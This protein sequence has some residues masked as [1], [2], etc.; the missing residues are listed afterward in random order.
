MLSRGRALWNCPLL[1][2]MSTSANATPPHASERP[3]QPPP[4]RLRNPDHIANTGVEEESTYVLTL[5][6]DHDFH[7]RM[8]NLRRL[9]FPPQ[10]NKIEAHITFFHALPGSQLDTIISDLLALSPTLSPFSLRTLEPMRLSN[11]VALNV[12][13]K[14]ADSIFNTL[15]QKWGPAGADF[16]SKQDQYFRAHYTIQNK[17]NKDV[18]LRTWE[19][20]KGHFRCDEGT[21]IGLTLYEYLAG[22]YW[23]FQRHFDFADSSVPAMSS[24]D[25]APLGGPSS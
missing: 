15:K 22:G 21:V 17:A 11:G 20:V 8:I 18:V 1:R 14:E 4:P 7:Q 9:Y 5:R 19:E 24:A 13:S 25:F 23:K 12:K 10:M 2:R 3:Q 16:L 6:T